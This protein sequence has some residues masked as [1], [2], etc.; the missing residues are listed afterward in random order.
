MTISAGNADVLVPT[1]QPGEQQH[2]RRI[3][4]W[5]LHINQDIAAFHASVSAMA[6][7][8]Q[9]ISSGATIVAFS[10]GNEAG[11]T[12]SAALTTITNWL[13]PFVDTASGFNT[14]TG[15]YTIPQNGTYEIFGKFMMSSGAITAPNEL[16]L[17]I[18]RN[19]ARAGV[20]WKGIDASVTNYQQVNTTALISCSVADTISLRM[21]L[22]A[23]QAGLYSGANDGRYYTQFQIHK[24]K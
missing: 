6:T 16:I 1:F 22:G 5:A 20:G 23:G 17:E 2:R 10:A 24:V 14:T 7:Q 3:A 11:Q 8:I 18:N 9:N 4:T 12:V 13:T 21:Q 19:G 15:V